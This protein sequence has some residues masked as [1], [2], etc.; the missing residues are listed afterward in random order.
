MKAWRVRARPSTGCGNG[1]AGAVPEMVLALAIFFQVHACLLSPE[2]GIKSDQ[3]LEIGCQPFMSLIESLDALPLPVPGLLQL[4]P[5]FGEHALGFRGSDA[6][7]T[8]RNLEKMERIEGG[9]KIV[10]A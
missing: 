8:G 1:R 4:V 3:P 9:A 5:P 2:T 7:L 10:F 6:S